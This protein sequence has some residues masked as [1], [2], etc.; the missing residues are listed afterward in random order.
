MNF[1]RLV[2]ISIRLLTLRC[3]DGVHARGATPAFRTGLERAPRI[4][5]GNGRYI[6]RSTAEF[7]DN[8]RHSREYAD[9]A[10]HGKSGVLVTTL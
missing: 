10:P 3:S 9:T 6:D 4:A 2:D 1:A 5:L 8:G 7:W